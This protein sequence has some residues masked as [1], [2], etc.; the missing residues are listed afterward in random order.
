MIRASINRRKKMDGRAKPGHDEETKS[1]EES[2]NAGCNFG[3]ALTP[4]WAG[5][6]PLNSYFELIAGCDDLR[7][8]MYIIPGNIVDAGVT[9]IIRCS[10][11]PDVYHRLVIRWPIEVA[12]G[13]REE[14]PRSPVMMQR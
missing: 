12:P 2:E 10:W 6:S 7:T 11:S 4:A 9:E 13:C 14:A 8:S 1:L 5:D 3:Q